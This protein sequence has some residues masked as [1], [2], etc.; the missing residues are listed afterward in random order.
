MVNRI[1]NLAG[2]VAPT[3]VSEHGF[4]PCDGYPMVPASEVR[5]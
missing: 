4:S 1:N 3:R 2:F 5:P